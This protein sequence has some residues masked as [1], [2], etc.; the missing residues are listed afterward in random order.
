MR[1]LPTPL[2]EDDQARGPSA[3]PPSKAAPETERPGLGTEFGERR[4]SSV[5]YTSLV[6]EYPTRP[7]HVVEVR[8][9]DRR[10][11]IA[12][13]IS[14]DEARPAAD[15]LSLRENADPFPNNRFASPPPAR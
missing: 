2:A 14:V 5:R 4:H 11:L 15:D 13:G 1:H 8:Y 3:T 12:L 9:D 10:G 7:S 6:R